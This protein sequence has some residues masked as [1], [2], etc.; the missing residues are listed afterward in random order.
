MN[1]LIRNNKV[2]VLVSKSYGAG[3]YSWHH[4]ERLL[5]EPKIIEMLEA[6]VDYHEIEMYCKATYG[7]DIYFGGIYDLH[8]CWVTV[9]KQFKIDEYDGAETLTVS[10]QVQWLTA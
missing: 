8:V 2:G 10:D 9:G 3:W 5:F 6:D 7:D 1:K 4:D